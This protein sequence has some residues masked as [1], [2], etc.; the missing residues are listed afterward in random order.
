MNDGATN[1][2][3]SVLDGT[4]PTV[5]LELTE[6]LIPNPHHWD[7]SNDPY[8]YKMP[9]EGDDPYLDEIPEDTDASRTSPRSMEH[10]YIAT[11]LTSTNDTISELYDSGATQH[12]TPY[13]E[14]LVNYTAIM[15]KP[16]N[17]E[18]Q[19]TFCAIRHGDLPIHIPNSPSFSNITLRDVLYTPDITQTLMSISLIDDAGYTV[20][21]ANG[22]CT[23]C[24]TAHMTISLFPKWEGLYKVDTYLSYSTSASLSDTSLSIGDA[25]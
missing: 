20:T 11:T 13:K 25:H 17:V 8:L 7:D 6:D 15:P 3:T 23:I 24:K 22:T 1:T 18:N 14:A 9:K 21:F 19:C 5:V 16:I 4:W 10:A 2:A 12:M